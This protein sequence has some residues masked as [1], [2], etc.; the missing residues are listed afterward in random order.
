MRWNCPAPTAA[1]IAHQ[2]ALLTG[3]WN[4]PALLQRIARGL[5]RHRPLRVKRVGFVMSAVCPVYPKQQTF[6]DQ[7]GTSHLCHNRTS[8]RLRQGQPEGERFDGS[9][10]RRPMHYSPLMKVHCPRCPVPDTSPCGAAPTVWLMHARAKTSIPSDGL[11]EV[12]PSSTQAKPV[13]GT[14]RYFVRFARHPRVPS[15]PGRGVQPPMVHPA[16][17]TS[18]ARDGCLSSALFEVHPAAQTYGNRPSWPTL[19]LG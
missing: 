10:R 16:I 9:K 5:D 19:R 13:H 8:K 3:Q 7:V 18:A 14:R 11:V 12:S 15:Q 4:F 1:R 6:P 2:L 17:P